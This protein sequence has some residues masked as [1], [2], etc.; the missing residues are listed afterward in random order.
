MKTN[1]NILTLLTMLTLIALGTGGVRAA[2]YPPPKIICYI[3]GTPLDS[4]NFGDEFC[5]VGDQNG[6]G[7]D[8]LLVKHDPDEKGRPSKADRVELFY[9]GNPMDS[10]YDRFFTLAGR[11]FGCART[12]SFVGQLLSQNS[13]SVVLQNYYWQTSTK[14]S[15]YFSSIYNIIPDMD[16]S[17]KFIISSK[18]PLKNIPAKASHRY[19]PIDFNGDGYHDLILTEQVV[20]SDTVRTGRVNIYYGGAVF[21]TIPDWCV[22]GSGMYDNFT[23]EISSGYDV[24]GDGYDD[25]LISYDYA[26]DVTSHGYFTPRFS[27]FLGGSP[28]DT[29]PAL[30]WDYNHFPQREMKSGFALL[31]DI[32]G[33]GYD[34]FGVGF[35]I[36]VGDG[37]YIFF[38]SDQPDL[39]PD[40]TLT[41]NL[42]GGGDGSDICGGDFNGDGYGDMV[43][44]HLAAYHGEG[45]V[46][47]TFGR[48]GSAKDDPISPDIVIRGDRDD[49]EP[50]SWL[51]KQVGAVGDYNGDGIDDFVTLTSIYTPSFKYSPGILIL[52]GSRQWA[53]RVSDTDIPRPASPEMIAFPNP[54]NGVAILSIR[55]AYKGLGSLTIYD[56]H[57]RKVWSVDTLEPNSSTTTLTWDTTNIPAGVYI[58]FLQYGSGSQIAT[59]SR[60]LVVL[61]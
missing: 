53:V 19:R 54:I 12:F 3:Q 36:G 27:L 49:F 22:V 5:W 60:K 58:V 50:Y 40:L 57:G 2:D 33:D 7:Y 10:E 17:P 38:G 47:L 31:P 15:E 8:D 9:G 48:P 39:I 35:G 32:N 29:I 52:A 26:S 14:P 59:V 21:D 37:Y 42:G 55:F 41:G 11:Y 43:T 24:N 16:E 28:P 18:A 56:I 51:G 20:W 30:T 4:T 25:F 1:I 61:K 45:R 46:G 6:D 44:S 34:D 23:V 13:R